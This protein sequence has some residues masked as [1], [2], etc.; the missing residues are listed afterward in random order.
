ML[1]TDVFPNDELQ[2]VFEGF[3]TDDQIAAGS[4]TVLDITPPQF[5]G[6]FLYTN[7]TTGDGI[8]QANNIPPFA[9]DINLF[10]NC[11]FYANTATLYSQSLNL[12]G[13]AQMIADF[14]G[15]GHPSITITNGT[16][17]ETFFFIVGEPEITNITTVA[18]SSGN[19][20]GK[21]FT[22]NSATDLNQYYFWYMVSGS[23]TDPAIANKTG[24][25]INI[26][27]NDSAN[28]VAAKTNNVINSLILDFTSS[29]STNVITV[30][31]VGEGV[32]TD[33][34]AGTSGFTVNVT[35]QG[36]GANPALNEVLLYDSISP[37]E[38]VNE[39]AQSLVNVINSKQNGIVNAFYLSDVQS[40]PGK[41]NCRGEQ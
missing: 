29:V 39:T 11:V 10:K 40:V 12:L 21:Y 31:T 36:A 19:L 17:T 26:N 7:A 8:L 35:Q 32:T 23:G 1:E 2:L 33:G 9:L 28:T 18:D 38:A 24:V 16:A 27:T 5:A 6:A 3:P 13:V 15:G 4:I 22:L 34:T 14:N 41:L 30:T 37:A 25:V 20:A